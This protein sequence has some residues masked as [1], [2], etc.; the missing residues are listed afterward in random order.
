[1]EHQREIRDLVAV[2][3]IAEELPPVGA[4]PLIRRENIRQKSK[5]RGL[6][7][8]G[9]GLIGQ[10]WQCHLMRPRQSQQFVLHSGG[11]LGRRL[12]R[13]CCK[14]DEAA[15]DDEQVFYPVMHF[16]KQKFPM[17][18]SSLGL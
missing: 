3:V 1:M 12:C 11:K 18:G 2:D 5:Q 7:S 9:C 6:E 8:A 14:S 13:P 10:A 4:L 16:R 17:L 15:G